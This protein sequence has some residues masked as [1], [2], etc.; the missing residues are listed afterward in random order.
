M[1]TAE[2][3]AWNPNYVQMLADRMNPGRTIITGAVER[4][5]L[6]NISI[7]ISKNTQMS[8]RLEMG[9]KGE[10]NYFIHTCDM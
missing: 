7:C 8:D 9:E 10:S 4:R 2:G 6:L 3:I 1:G 5:K